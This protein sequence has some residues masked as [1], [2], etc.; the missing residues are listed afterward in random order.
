MPQ[1]APAPP[2][3]QV[4]PHMHTDRLLSPLAWR[5]DS[6][7]A[8]RWLVSLPDACRAELDA[9]VQQWRKTPQP[10]E[11]LTPAAYELSAC[12]QLM[13]QV[14]EQLVYHTGMA[15]IDRIPVECYSAT[16]N[17]AIGWLLASC[18]GVVMEQKW[19]GT[20]LYDVKDSGKAL[21][22]GVRR[23][24]TSLEQDFHTDGGWLRQPPEFVGLFCLQPAQTGGRSRAVSLLTVHDIL[25]RQRP[26]LLQRLYQ[27]FWWDRQAEHAPDDV[28][29][30]QHPVYQYDGHT[31]RAR[32]YDDYIRHGHRL[33]RTVLDEAGQAALS[34]M[35][36][37]MDAPEN[38]I[39][40]HLDKGQLQ[41]LN[42]YQ[43]A[44]SRTTF[45]DAQE[46]ALRRHLLRLWNRTTGAAALEGA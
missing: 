14:R 22:Y 13:G 34:A 27:P 46:P 19:D 45:V 39:E 31:L 4:I 9:V 38:W 25:Q 21:G 10:L 24:V 15:I 5:R 20:R 2:H 37:V 32:V 23:S 7:S 26:D 33:A 42:N 29:Y 17:K 8:E 16:E 35:R 18:L 1:Q 3:A 44:H 41:Y 30:S 43:C 12:V 40:L 11:Q 36:V 28:P 6:M